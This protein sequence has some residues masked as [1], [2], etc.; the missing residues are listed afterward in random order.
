MPLIAGILFGYLLAKNKLLSKHLKILAD[1]DL[2]TGLLNRSMFI[3]LLKTEI[4]KTSRYG[5]TFSVIFIDI[6]HFKS[7]NDQHGHQAGDKVLSDF[8]QLIMEHNRISDISARYGGEEFVIL[9]TSSDIEATTK[10]AERLRTAVANHHFETAGHITCSFGIAEFK[11]DE[12]NYETLLKRADEA[13]YDAK[14]NGR[15]RIEVRN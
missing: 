7:V 4:L 10:H 14:Q 8:S 5:G 6:D 9:S 2:L 13:L 3:H 12:D 15:N 1:T 11:K